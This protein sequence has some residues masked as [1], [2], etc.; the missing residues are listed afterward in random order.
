ML[1]LDRT[2]IVAVVL[3][4]RP[5]VVVVVDCFRE[6]LGGEIISLESCGCVG[7]LWYEH[8][9]HH[10]PKCEN[11][12]CSEFSKL[13]FGHFSSCMNAFLR[14]PEHRTRVTGSSRVKKQRRACRLSDLG[15]VMNGTA[16]VP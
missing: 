14:W 13:E 6:A 12:E 2:D 4:V 9:E 16:R 15:I 11:R 10:E 5:H 7:V 3:S 8:E 1:I